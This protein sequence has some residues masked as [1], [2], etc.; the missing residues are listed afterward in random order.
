MALKNGFSWGEKNP[1]IVG[2]ITPFIAICSGAH[3]VG[4]TIMIHFHYE[5]HFWGQLFLCPT[6]PYCTFTHL[7]LYLSEQAALQAVHQFAQITRLFCSTTATGTF[8]VPSLLLGL[9]V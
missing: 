3:L 8:I 1:T 6:F 9:F 7:Y 2:I 5:P 4:H